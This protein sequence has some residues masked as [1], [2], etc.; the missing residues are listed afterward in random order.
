MSAP[1]RT[2]LSA[3]TRLRAL[4]FEPRHWRAAAVLLAGLVL[5]EVNVLGSHFFTR[6]D[7]SEQCRFTLSEP[8]QR[9]LHAQRETVTITA[10]LTRGDPLYVEARHLL[11]AYRAE[12]SSLRV[13]FVDPDRDVAEYRSLELDSGADAGEA[14][15]GQP[16]F[17]VESG[18]RRWLVPHSQL[19][20]R[21]EGGVGSDRLEER[22]TQALVRVMD[23]KRELVC[24]VTGHGERSV[25]DVGPNGLAELGRR[26]AQSNLE[27]RRTPLD[28]PDPGRAL[29]DCDVVALIGPER[30]LPN[31][32]TRALA[33]AF[34]RRANLLLLIDP[35]VDARTQLTSVGLEPLLQP[36]GVELRAGFVLERD[37]SS[38]LPRGMGEVFFAQVEPHA[39]TRG[40]T[41]DSERLD[42]RPV[43]VASQAIGLLRPEGAQ[44]LLRA[45]SRA[46]LL[47]DLASGPAAAGTGSGATGNQASGTA[48]AAGALVVAAAIEG[49]ETAPQGRAAALRPTPTAR[50]FLAG[51]ANVAAADS[52]REP[53]LYANRLLVENAFAWLTERPSVVAVPPR[54]VREAGL[55]LSEE[56]LGDLLRYVL[57]YMPATAALLG[58][59]VVLRRRSL[60][61]RSRREAK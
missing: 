22:L 35:L 60:E 4:R 61:Q 59:F 12:T 42:A 20:S 46:V 24:F 6:F 50:L 37:P 44:P 57:L 41:T 3:R 49:P 43:L 30:P 16:A 36:L 1:E 5:G 32:H 28:V 10:L 14:T 31:E 29:A 9:L 54:E 33:D 38:R 11:D 23:T 2:W 7:C 40:L 47:N 56:S 21:D 34:A 13:R 17:L 53:Q 45:S 48:Q 26:L 18:G 52:F 8:T 51:S 19:L 27:V 25:E 39:V 55:T 15:A 58:L